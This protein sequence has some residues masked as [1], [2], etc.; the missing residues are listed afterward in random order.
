MG[1]LSALEL[2]ASGFV[3]EVL[4]TTLVAWGRGWGG[5]IDEKK[6]GPTCWIAPTVPMRTISPTSRRH[7]SC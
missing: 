2:I 7:V 3:G 5:T 1:C 6:S 4:S